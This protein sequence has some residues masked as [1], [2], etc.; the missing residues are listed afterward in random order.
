MRVLSSVEGARPVFT[1]VMVLSL[2][3]IVAMGAQ[4]AFVLRQG[5]RREKGRAG[6]RHKKT[7]SQRFWDLDSVRHHLRGP[8][9]R[10]NQL[11][12]MNRQKTTNM[13]MR[14]WLISMV[15]FLEL[16]VKVETS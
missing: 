8:L 16:S 14:M 5:L 2:G 12:N 7:A 11:A 3:L 9:G 13:M 4:N 1:Q 10:L 15:F 6:D